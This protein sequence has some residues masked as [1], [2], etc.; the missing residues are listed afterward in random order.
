M[1]DELYYFKKEINRL[2]PT[3]RDEIIFIYEYTG[4]Y[5]YGNNWKK[6]KKYLYEQDPRKNNLIFHKLFLIIKNNFENI[7][8][9]KY[10][11]TKSLHSLN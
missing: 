4:E 10:I 8:L 6:Y 3:N 1:Y 2:F 9:I 7:E 5:I 11:H